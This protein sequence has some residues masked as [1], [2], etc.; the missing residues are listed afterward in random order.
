MTHMLMTIEIN[1]KGRPCVTVLKY[2]KLLVCT[3]QLE[4]QEE[5]VS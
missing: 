3:R 1:K 5:Q 4:N 2:Q